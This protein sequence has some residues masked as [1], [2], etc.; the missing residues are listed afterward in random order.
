MKYLY[1]PGCSLKGTAIDY[2]ESFKALAPLLG[3]EIKEL[4]DWGCCGATVARSMSSELADHLPSKALRQGAD[5]G[6]DLLMLC[7]NCY[8][9]HRR[10][11]GRLEED[12][13]ARPDPS[14]PGLPE[15][16]QLLEV[17]AF[18]IGPE[19]IKKKLVYSLSGIKALPYYGCLTVRPYLPGGTESR[20]NPQI[21]ERM[22]DITG[23]Q[24]VVF[25]YK[26][27]CCGGALLLTKEKV[28]LKLAGTI[29][30]EAKRLSPDCLVVACPLCHFMLDAKQSAIE[31]ELGEKIEIPVLYITQLLGIAMGIDHNKLGIPRLITSPKGLLCKLD[32]R[33]ISS[34]AALRWREAVGAGTAPPW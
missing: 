1:Y 28:A 15:V 6:M 34:D 11:L 26:V 33:V 27:D 32:D 8:L 23:A 24:P 5:E 3:I 4:N 18:D 2:E 14:L 17:L 10:V 29:L 12:I 9:N 16:R 7:P 19:E 20:E 31:R 30:K 13:C 21:M 22:I 25:P